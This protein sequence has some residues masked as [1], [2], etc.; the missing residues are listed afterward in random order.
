M[1]KKVL[2]ASHDAGSANLLSNWAKNYGYTYDYDFLLKGPAIKI[3]KQN[4]PKIIIKKSIPKNQNYIFVITGTSLIS[5]LEIDVINSFKKK[6]KTIAFIDHWINYKKRFI[7]NNKYILPD[8]IWVT[9]IIAFKLAKK[10]FK[11]ITI[12]LKYNYYLI[13]LKKNFK[14]LDN[15]NKKYDYIFAS[16]NF[17][18]NTKANPM[19]NISSLEIFIKFLSKLSNKK[20]KILFKLH[21]SENIQ[22]YLLI[23][24]KYNNVFFDKNMSMIKCLSLS[25]TLVGC[26]TMALV[27]A[28]KLGLRT[29]NLDIGISSIRSIP[30][31]YI[32]KTLNII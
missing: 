32:D 24:K 12:K 20:A 25:T 1:K 2:I 29:I 8:E 9:D 10:I 15:K 14:K 4:F 27:V 30:D 16:N 5:R 21:P 17:K 13:N 22:K 7:K 3:F 28:K 31:K 19:I 26:E 11:K 23:R 6:I 18:K